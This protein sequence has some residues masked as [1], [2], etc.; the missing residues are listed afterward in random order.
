MF[1]TIFFDLLPSKNKKSP[2]PGGRGGSGGQGQELLFS[3][4]VPKSSGE[5]TCSVSQHQLLMLLF[6]VGS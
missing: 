2:R 1:L 5:Y 4:G 3:P 6:A